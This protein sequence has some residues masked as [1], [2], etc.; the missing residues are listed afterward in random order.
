LT[1]ESGSRNSR[2]WI[3]KGY[4]R[5]DQGPIILM[6]ENLPDRIF[7][8]ADAPV[9]LSCDRSSTGTFYRRTALSLDARSCH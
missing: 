7:L 9:S 2:G 4:Y 1:Q 8:A 6:I 5:L 3:S